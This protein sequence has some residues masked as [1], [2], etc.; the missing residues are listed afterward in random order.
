MRKKISCPVFFS[1]IRRPPRSTLFPYTR[2]SDLVRVGHQN[3]LVVAQFPGIEIV[4]ADASAQR[5]DDGANFLVAEHL[6]VTRL[7]D[8]KNFAL[9]RQDSL[10]FTVAAHLRRAAGRF[11][12][13]DEQ[14]APRGIALLA[15]GEFSRQAARIHR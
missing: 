11:A 1:M 2:S 14:L 12:F 10:I 9:E 3:D 4:L 8:V 6:V 7:F 15:I 5:R 13:D